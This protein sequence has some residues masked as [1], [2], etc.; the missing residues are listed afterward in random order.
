MPPHH[1]WRA[2]TGIRVDDLLA[3]LDEHPG[4]REVVVNLGG[5]YVELVA[6]APDER[7]DALVLTLHSDDTADVLRRLLRLHQPCA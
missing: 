6:A 1:T 5:T 3:A 4:H 7:R 2:R